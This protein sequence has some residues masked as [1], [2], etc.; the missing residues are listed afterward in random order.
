M[1]SLYSASALRQSVP[2]PSRNQLSA[3]SELGFGQI[4]ARVVGADQRLQGEPRDV[5]AAALHVADGL[6]EQNL[7]GLLVSLVMGFSYFLRRNPQEL[8][9]PATSTATTIEEKCCL[10]VPA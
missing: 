4:L 5:V 1:K 10:F 8:R 7:V 2:P 6:I 9:S 3:I